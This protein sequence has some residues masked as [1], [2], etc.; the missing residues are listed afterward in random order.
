M[1]NPISRREWKHWPGRQQ[2]SESVLPAG[3]QDAIQEHIDSAFLSKAGAR[4]HLEG[5]NQ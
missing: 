5:D 1:P 4:T 2:Q 3:V